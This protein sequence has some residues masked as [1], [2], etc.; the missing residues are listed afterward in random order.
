MWMVLQMFHTK[1][2][3]A[4]YYSYGLVW[5]SCSLRNF[6]VF[7]HEVLRNT[8]QAIGI[9]TSTLD[10]WLHSA[11]MGGTGWAPFVG[12]VALVAVLAFCWYLTL[13]ALV[14]ELLF[15][16]VLHACHYIMTRL[17]CQSS[18]L[19]L[20]LLR[21]VP[22]DIWMKFQKRPEVTGHRSCFSRS[23]QLVHWSIDVHS[24]IMWVNW[25]DAYLTLQL[26]QDNTQLWTSGLWQWPWWESEHGYHW[27][28]SCWVQS[29]G[30]GEVP[31]CLTAGKSCNAREGV[32]GS[33]MFV[34]EPF[35][36]TKWATI[37]MFSSPAVS[38]R[39]AI[40]P[41]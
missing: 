36:P 5:Y 26:L 7:Q 14:T 3:M 34:C 19:I 10:T 33:P 41:G 1:S 9:A 12:V 25:G 8:E 22:A 38:S 23:L 11:D 31:R 17:R 6:S 30:L 13:V 18:S 16:S 29:A 4:C 15:Y 27:Y 20:S 32:G 28:H 40:H 37:L 21:K 35:L 24:M 2:I 39:V